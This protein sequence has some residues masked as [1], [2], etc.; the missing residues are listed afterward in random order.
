MFF[1]LDLPRLATGLLTSLAVGVTEFSF[2]AI[3]CE[4]LFES[5]D[6][7]LL[8]IA[9][10]AL[11]IKS[12]SKITIHLIHTFILLILSHP[13]DHF[14]F[15]FSPIILFPHFKWYLNLIIIL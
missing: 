4:C 11:L 15:H 10:R 2:L 3:D 1:I 8:I 9:Y 13:M 7:G 14:L 5:R 12:D 6:W